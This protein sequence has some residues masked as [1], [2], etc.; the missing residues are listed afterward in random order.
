MIQGR[1]YIHDITAC[2][3]IEQFLF[4]LRVGADEDEVRLLRAACEKANN[5]PHELRCKSCFS[6]ALVLSLIY[7][8]DAPTD[9]SKISANLLFMRSACSC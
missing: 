7:G 2:T 4:E 5:R 9:D 1:I 3:D 8:F 6:S